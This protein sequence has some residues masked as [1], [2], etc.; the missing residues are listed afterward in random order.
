MIVKCFYCGADVEKSAGHANRARKLGM[1]MFCD[2]KCFG[3]S[4]RSLLSNV[5]KAEQKRLY[6]MEYRAKNSD[7]IKQRKDAY[8]KT[9]VGRA[10]QKRNRDNRKEKHKEYIRR[11]EY[12]EWKQQYDKVHRAKKLYGEFWESIII[13]NQIETVI[14]PERKKSKIQKGTF[15]KSQKRK[16]LWNSTQKTLKTPSGTHY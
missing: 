9:P 1:Y 13:L 15:N 16:R 12:K 8:Y 11:P 4:R 6:D 10:A 5:E 14:E 2:K 3:L 7:T